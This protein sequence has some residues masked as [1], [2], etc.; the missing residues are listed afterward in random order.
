MHE[1]ALDYYK[2]RLDIETPTS[3]AGKR[4]LALEDTPFLRNWHEKMELIFSEHV[5]TF[6]FINVKSLQ[7]LSQGNHATN[8]VAAALPGGKVQLMDIYGN[9]LLEFVTEDGDEVIEIQSNPRG[10]SQNDDMFVAVLTEKNALYVF[11][12]E[13]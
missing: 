9:F 3:E 5:R 8:I 7:K 1:D 13:I 6:Q 2:F 12:F 11:S 4:S 10:Q